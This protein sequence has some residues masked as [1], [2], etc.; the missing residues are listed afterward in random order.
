MGRTYGSYCY[1][2]FFQRIEIRCYKMHRGYASSIHIIGTNPELDS[3]FVQPEFSI[4]IL[5]T[6]DNIIAAGL[7]N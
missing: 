2:L 5:T 1:S 6:A 4:I 3:G 7:R